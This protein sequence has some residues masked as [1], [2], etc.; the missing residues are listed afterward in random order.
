MKKDAKSYVEP[1]LPVDNDSPPRPQNLLCSALAL[2]PRSESVLIHYRPAAIVCKVCS[3]AV[4]TDRYNK[5]EF[6][7]PGE[8]DNKPR[9]KSTAAV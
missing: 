3:R 5:Y 6:K 1:H 8:N 2:F 7:T 9:R 4:S